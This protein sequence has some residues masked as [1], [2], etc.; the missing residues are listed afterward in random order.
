MGWRIR[1]LGGD[2]LTREEVLNY[3]RDQYGTEPEYP[4]M[5]TPLAAVLRH[6]DNAKW[7]G[8][9][10]DVTADKVGGRA[11]E[12][13]DILNLKGDPDEIIHIREMPGFAPAYHMN[14]KHWLTVILPE[15]K[16]PA[17]VFRLIDKS[18]DLTAPKRSY[19]N[20]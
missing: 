2:S 14:K 20:G 3:C 17:V 7:Y 6:R 1:R 18:Y 16:D 8:L 13:I 5:E 15:M 9:I 11:G 19:Q 10:M 4:W 12:T